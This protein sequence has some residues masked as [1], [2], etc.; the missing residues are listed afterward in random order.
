MPRPARTRF[1][2]PPRST[3]WDP[4]PKQTVITRST[5]GSEILT[6]GAQALV[7]GLTFVRIH[8]YVNLWLTASDI[9]G[10]GFSGALGM[11]IVT[12]NAFG[13]GITAVPTPLTDVGW[14]GWMWHSFFNIATNTAT[15]TD[16]VNAS[17]SSWSKEIDTKSM[18]KI[19]ETDVLIAVLEVFEVANATLKGYFETRVLSKLP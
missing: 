16:G 3:A 9:I 14:D 10:G 13:I 1:R 15:L 18:R 5:P 19:K 6:S 12:E 11:C 8:G 4:G 17:N 7:S 2:S